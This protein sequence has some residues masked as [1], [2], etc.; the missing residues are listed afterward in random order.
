ML[1]WQR[2]K[3]SYPSPRK[4][5]RNT[6]PVRLAGGALF[7]K[8]SGLGL[9]SFRIIDNYVGT[10]FVNKFHMKLLVFSGMRVIIDLEIL[11]V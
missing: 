9:I 1:H 3:T 7:V 10:Y 8:S 11:G 5:Q 4:R 2:S 6:R